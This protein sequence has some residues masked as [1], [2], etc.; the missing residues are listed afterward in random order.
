MFQLIP[1]SLAL[2]IRVDRLVLLHLLFCLCCCVVF[3]VLYRALQ[4]GATNVRAAPCKALAGGWCG[5]LMGLVCWRR[6]T[7]GFH[8]PGVRQGVVLESQSETARRR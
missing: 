8:V 1:R 5:G 4:G 2:C 6:S 7:E 3:P